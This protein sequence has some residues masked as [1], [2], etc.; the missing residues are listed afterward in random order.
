MT[1]TCHAHGCT[2]AVP[3]KMFMCKEHWFK[4]RQKT[5]AAIWREYTQGQE[6]TKE[7]TVRYLAVQQYAIG[8]AAFRPND[9]AAVAAP[10]IAKAHE[11]RDAAIRAGLG[12]PLVDLVSKTEPSVSTGQCMKILSVWGPWA[13]LICL[14]IKDVENRGWMTSYRGPLAIHASKGGHTAREVRQ[15]L[16]ELV[17]DRMITAAQANA[18]EERV[19]TDRGKVIGVVQ[20]V[21]CRATSKSPWWVKDQKALEL[22]D[23]RLL[24]VPIPHRGEQGL[25]DFVLEVTA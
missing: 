8:E 21:G 13:Q 12:D 15:I 3:P 19:D 11:W 20:L 6:V 25:R 22:A 18:I 2:V 23:A 14:G 10:Y 5:R 24:D 17:R 4:L 16:V 9:E 1:H 7:P